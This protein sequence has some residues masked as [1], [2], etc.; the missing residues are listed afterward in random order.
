MLHD[1][2]RTAASVRLAVVIGL[3]K[4]HGEKMSYYLIV[5]AAKLPP[6]PI[7]AW[8]KRLDA[9][10]RLKFVIHPSVKFELGLSGFCPIKVTVPGRWPFSSSQSY[11]SGFEMSVRDFDFESHFD[12]QNGEVEAKREQLRTEGL[13]LEHWEHFKSQV[14][15]SF[16]PSNMFEARL[17]FLSAAILTEELVGTCVDPQ[18]GETLDQDRVFSWATERVRQNDLDTQGQ[19]LISHPFEGWK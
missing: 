16:K 9:Y 14:F 12:L 2:E 8:M 17:S 13:D 10:D 19:N 5:Y 1:D 7:P 18:T 3:V 11:M 15:I 4:S 6:N